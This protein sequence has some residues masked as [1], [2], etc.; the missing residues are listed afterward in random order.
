MP[1]HPAGIG[2]NG[3]ADRVPNPTRGQ[4]WRYLP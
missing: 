3:N 2:G 1:G 4:A